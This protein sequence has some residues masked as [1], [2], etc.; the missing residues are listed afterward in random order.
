MP[1]PARLLL[2]ALALAL[3]P[4]CAA[5]RPVHFS[6]EP[7]GARVIVDGTD[8]GFV[9]P[10]MLELANHP[11]RRIDFV[12]PGFETATRQLGLKRRGELV[13][14]RDSSVHYRTW[15]FP[16]WLSSEDFFIFYKRQGGEF[17]SRIF[18]RMR[19]EADR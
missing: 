14:W 8:S 18:V 10:C 11:S 15:N 9:T 13:Y 17:P 5:P 12:L 7:P 4:A 3:A 2:L 6:S 19:R 16:L 1:Q